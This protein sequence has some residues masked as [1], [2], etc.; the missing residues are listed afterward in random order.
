MLNLF[1]KKNFYDG[2][3]NVMYFFVP[4]LIIDFLIIISSALCIP[5]VTIFKESQ[6]Y[7]YVWFAAIIL[8]SAA[9]GVVTVT[10]SETAAGIADYDT[11]DI[12]KFF[13]DIKN[14]ISD[15]IKFGLTILAVLIYSI[16]VIRF[17][18]FP[19][20]ENQTV[21]FV[22][23]LAGTVY[24]WI[25]FTIFLALSWY[26]AVRAN[27]HNGYRKSIKKC[28]IILF[29]NLFASLI[30]TFYEMG[31]ILISIIMLGIAPGMA[32]LVLSR[33][34]AMRLLMKKYDYIEELDK[35]G[36]PANSQARRK[37]PWK[38]L[39]AEEEEANPVRTFKDFWLPWKDMK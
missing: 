27:L 25:A 24:V 33:C 17:F 21:T 31:L 35:K 38:E 36:E 37:I 3:D 18:F 13:K 5:G 30:I 16:F 19:T 28:F 4:N 20:G 15:G 29:D 11:V 34:N 23:L 32:G 6:W 26:P 9:A 39:L 2:W 7:L 12:K 1:F 8:F 14:C 22:G 10:W